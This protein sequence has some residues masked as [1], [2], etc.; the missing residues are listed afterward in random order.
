MIEPKVYIDE[1]GYDDEDSPIEFIYETKNMDFGIPTQKKEI[2]ESLS[3]V[4]I[5]RLAE[6]KQEIIVD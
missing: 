5:N 2:W 4:A 6:L 3:Y 1:Y